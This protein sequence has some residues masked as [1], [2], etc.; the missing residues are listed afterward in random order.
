MRVFKLSRYTEGK[1]IIYNTFLASIPALVIMLVFMLVI[2]VIFGSA[3]YYSEMGKFRMTEQ[4]PE[5]PYEAGL[6]RRGGSESVFQHFDG[7]LL[8]GKE[9][10]REGGLREEVQ[11]CWPTFV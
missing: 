8:G 10:G 2:T 7:M 6:P 11:K 9:G 3:I 4:Y 5:G 1:D